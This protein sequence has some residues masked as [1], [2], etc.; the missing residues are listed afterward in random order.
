MKLFLLSEEI[1]WGK[2]SLLHCRL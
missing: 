2:T 1:V